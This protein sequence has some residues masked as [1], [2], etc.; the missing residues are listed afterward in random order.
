MKG[1]QVLLLWL[2]WSCSRTKEYIVDLNDNNKYNVKKSHFYYMNKDSILKSLVIHVIWLALI[3]KRN[4]I[5]WINY[6]DVIRTWLIL[7]ITEVTAP[8]PH[9]KEVK[10]KSKIWRHLWLIHSDIEELAESLIEFSI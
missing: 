2:K 4:I 8:Y 5:T 6:R 10:Q 7:H 9:E 1:N 3:D